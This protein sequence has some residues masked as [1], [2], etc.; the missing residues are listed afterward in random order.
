MESNPNL[1]FTLDVT[2]NLQPKC[3]IFNRKTSPGKCLDLVI[4]ST[5][6]R[7]E[8]D[9][10]RIEWVLRGFVARPRNPLRIRIVMILS[11]FCGFAWV[12]VDCQQIECNQ[13]P[14]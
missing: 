4:L 5:T 6:V 12:F 8:V 10:A 7:F 13:M 3:I 2:S 11:G 9:W 14:D 1:G